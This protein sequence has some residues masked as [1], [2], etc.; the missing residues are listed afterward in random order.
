MYEISVTTL[1]KKKISI[2]LTCYLYFVFSQLF[3]ISVNKIPSGIQQ[4]LI[5]SFTRTVI[6]K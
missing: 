4:Y 3:Q 6:E 1:L 5:V 2:R